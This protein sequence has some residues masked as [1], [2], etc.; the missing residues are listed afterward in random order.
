MNIFHVL[1]LEERYMMR[2]NTKLI[3]FGLLVFCSFVSPFISEV[4]ADNGAKELDKFQ[5]T[6]ILISG[7]MSGKKIAD[8]H[9]K[10]NKITYKG[11][12]GELTS[13]HQ[14]KETIVFDIVKLDPTKSPKEVSLIRKTGPSAGKTITAIYEFDGNDQFKFA[15]DPAGLTIPKDFNTKEGS[16][17]VS[18][19]WKRV[20]P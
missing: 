5:G 13:P 1:I 6:W 19:A 17:H 15:F 4:V 3:A 2:T 7:E 12:K 14:S 9:V 8:D 18:H 11:N 16:G 10:Q 20:K